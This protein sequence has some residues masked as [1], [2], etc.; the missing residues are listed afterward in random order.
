[1][2]TTQWIRINKYLEYRYKGPKWIAFILVKAKDK[3]V[4]PI[5]RYIF[6]VI[7]KFFG[8]E[9]QYRRPLSDNPERGFFYR[10]LTE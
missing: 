7:C 4:N 3:K 10:I 2:I 5:L 8:G 9:L 6:E 1:M